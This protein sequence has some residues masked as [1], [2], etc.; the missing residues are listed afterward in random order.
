MV[1]TIEEQGEVV[2]VRGEYI[3]LIRLSN[4]LDLPGRHQH[5]CDAIVVVTHH[6][7]RKYGLMVDELLGEQQVVLKNLGTATPKVQ[8]ISG[9]TIMGDGRVALVLD[10]AG[11]VATAHA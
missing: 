10:V 8:D 2:N 9:G 4:V 11:I 6:E 7:K 5:P 3:P 1:H